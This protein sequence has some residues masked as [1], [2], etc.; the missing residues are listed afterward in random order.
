[1]PIREIREIRSFFLPR[2]GHQKNPEIML[3]CACEAGN[4]VKKSSGAGLENPE[5]RVSRLFQPPR[6][7]SG[8]TSLR[9]PIPICANLRNL[10]LKN[11]AF[12]GAFPVAFDKVDKVSDKARDKVGGS[13]LFQP[14]HRGG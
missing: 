8:R 9:H 4:P 10:R 2:S 7:D 14:P 3:I 12:A 6:R 1:M 13:G 11:R 5:T